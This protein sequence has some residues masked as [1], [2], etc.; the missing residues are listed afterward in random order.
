MNFINLTIN[1]LFNEVLMKNSFV[2]GITIFFMLNISIL[3]AQWERANTGLIYNGNYVRFILVYCMDGNNIFAGSS[4]GGIYYSSDNG[5]NWIAKNNG[6]N[7]T[8]IS[9]IVVNGN[10]LYAGTEGGMY[11]SENKGDSW[12]KILSNFTISTIAFKGSKIFG[13]YFR[14]IKIS[15]DKGE[16]WNT[17]SLSS[18][19]INIRVL[20]TSKN[21]IFAGT[22]RGIYFSS[23]DGGSWSTI[24]IGIPDT[25]S[26]KFMTKYKDNIYAVCAKNEFYLSTDDGVSWNHLN[27][28]LEDAAVNY[29]AVFEN[30]Y[31]LV[32]TQNYGILIS[33]DNGSNWTP[34]NDGLNNLEIYTLGINDEYVFASNNYGVYR[35]KLED[36]GISSVNE[37]SYINN[38]NISPNPA[39]EV[40]NIRIEGLEGQNCKLT[41]YDELGNPLSGAFDGVMTSDSKTI[42]CDCRNLVSGVYFM[43]LICGNQIFTRTFGVIR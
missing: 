40:I 27:N 37:N 25:I 22:S 2:I 43:R 8:T 35:A 21:N 26:V 14:W 1:I 6:L 19:L 42:N 20:L 28:N 9:A 23:D 12:E 11:L 5:S 38:L 3:S 29:L 10:R 16:N 17:I 33:T 13:G 31:Y 18:K 7:D 24:S 4:D 15:S 41:I 30:N 32:A 39:S 34:F 36:L